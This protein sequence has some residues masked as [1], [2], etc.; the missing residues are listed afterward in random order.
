RSSHGQEAYHEK[1]EHCQQNKPCVLFHV[2]SPFKYNLFV[3]KW[4]TEI[5]LKGILLSSSARTRRFRGAAPGFFTPFTF[6]AKRT[7][8]FACNR[9]F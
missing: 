3:N 6:Y 7:E 9:C 1:R 2:Y 8:K 4:G 5:E